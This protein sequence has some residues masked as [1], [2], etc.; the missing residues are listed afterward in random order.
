MEFKIAQKMV[1]AALALSG[2]AFAQS[3]AAQPDYTLSFNVGAVSDYRFRGLTQSRFNPALQGG[4]DFAHKSGFYLGTWAST[5]KWIEDA[6]GDAPVELDVYGGYKGSF[7]AVGYDVGVLR[8]QYPRSELA[9]SPNTTEIY[10]AGSFGPL[11]LKYSHAVTN[12]FGFASSKNS[13]YLDASASFDLGNGFSLVPHVGYQK[14]KNFS[15]GSYTDYALTVAK[16]FGNGFSASAAVIGT[17]A[18]DTVYFTP[19][20]KFSGKN[21]LVVG[22][23][24]SF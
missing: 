6:G 7:G 1:L 12:A 5:I 13:Y 19:S 10:G 14:I 2:A 3:P 15:A 23:K 9:V 17:D 4:A 24:Y 18:D 11:T 20:G 8:Y 21:G 16:D 22:V